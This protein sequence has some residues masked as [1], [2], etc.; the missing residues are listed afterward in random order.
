MKS[1]QQSGLKKRKTLKSIED[2]LLSIFEEMLPAIRLKN[3]KSIEEEKQIHYPYLGKMLSAIRF[4]K[5]LKSTEEKTNYLILI[6]AKQLSD[7]S[8]LVWAAQ[9]MSARTGRPSI[10]FGKGQIFQSIFSFPYMEVF[11][12]PLYGRRKKRSAAAA[13]EQQGWTILDPNTGRPVRLVAYWKF[14]KVYFIKVY[15]LSVFFKS[16]SKHRETTSQIGKCSLLETFL[17]WTH[18]SSVN[19]LKLN[20]IFCPNFLTTLHS[21]LVAAAAAAWVQQTRIWATQLQSSVKQ[22]IPR[23]VY[24]P[25]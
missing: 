18:L 5:N 9:S 20:R 13:R 1:C 22:G 4:S 16:G 23:W 15:F 2:K 10:C 3:F 24:W 17:I 25:S 8:R 11:R 7:N 14:L 21:N 6:W 12:N 19:P